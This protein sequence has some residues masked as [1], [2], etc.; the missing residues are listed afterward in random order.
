MNTVLI[1]GG[2]GGIG[3]AIIRLLILSN[4]Y[5]VNVDRKK[6][7]VCSDKIKNIEIELQPDNV[8]DIMRT[9]L[10]E[11]DIHIFISSIGYYGTKDINH[12]DLSDHNKTMM[13]NVTV[14]L[15]AS[16]E[17]AKKMVCGKI[18]FISSAAAYVG[19]RDLSYSASK[20]A[21]NGIVHGLAKSLENHSIYT[22]GIAPG[23]IS[24]N[25]SDQMTNQRQNDTI[26]RT[27]N[28][29]KGTAVEV[30]RVVRFLVDEDSGYMNGSII[31]L[32][33]GLYF[34]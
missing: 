31:H 6:S 24:T 34:N 33:N 15:L 25:M 32:N 7:E 17:V 4:Y 27:L 23:I 22:Y 21:V 2:S 10:D 26:E 19:S 20:A 30:A 5:I 29:R 9:I 12:F 14:P 11:H 1:L 8:P 13:T 18:I 3:E 16:I 28:K